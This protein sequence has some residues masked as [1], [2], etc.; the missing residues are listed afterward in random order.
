MYGMRK[1]SEVLV[2]LFDESP[3]CKACGSEKLKK[4][5]L[6]HLPYP[7]PPGRDFRSLVIRPAAAIRLDILTAPY[8]AVAA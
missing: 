2:T 8:Q 7:E 4:L 3:T 5:L 6:P 1:M